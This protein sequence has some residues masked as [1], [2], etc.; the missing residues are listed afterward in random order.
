MTCEPREADV[1]P[2]PAA[3]RHWTSIFGK[4]LWDK[5]HKTQ[6]AG[7]LVEKVAS[8]PITFYFG[9]TARSGESSHNGAPAGR[10]TGGGAN[11]REPIRRL[12]SSS[13]PLPHVRIADRG[14]SSAYSLAVYHTAPPPHLRK[15]EDRK[16]KGEQRKISFRL[17]LWTRS[18]CETAR[19]KERE[20]V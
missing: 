3:Q 14:S 9:P 13:P 7:M 20:K 12:N 8:V 6:E 4:A 17:I 18:Q 19:A 5:G 1:V 16:K 10:E 15:T 2:T 11:L